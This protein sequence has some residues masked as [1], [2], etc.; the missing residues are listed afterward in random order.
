MGHNTLLTMT[1]ILY[2]RNQLSQD[3]KLPDLPRHNVNASPLPALLA[4]TKS[5][6]LGELFPS[7]SIRIVLPP[8]ARSG[9][10]YPLA[11]S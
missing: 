6:M 1:T 8:L 10:I 7:A 4:L 9:G 2:H 5:G 11:I 3:A